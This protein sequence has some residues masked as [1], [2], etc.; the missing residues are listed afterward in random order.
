MQNFMLTTKMTL[1]FGFGASGR[2]GNHLKFGT[3]EF[4]TPNGSPGKRARQARQARQAHLPEFSCLVWCEEIRFPNFP[5][6]FTGS[7]QLK[8]KKEGYFRVQ[9][10]KFDR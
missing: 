1:V 8:T 9:W 5:S 2:R 4:F 10:V 6:D 3:F 7:R